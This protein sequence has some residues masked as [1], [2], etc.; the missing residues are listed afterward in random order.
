METYRFGNW[1]EKLLCGVA[2]LLVGST[3]GLAQTAE[4][5]APTSSLSSGQVDT[6]KPAIPT[7]QEIILDIPSAVHMSR[8]QRGEINGLRYVLFP[9]GTGTVMQAGELRTALYRLKCTKGV[10]CTITGEGGVS[11]NVP[12]RGAPE[13][14]LPIAP[15]GEALA[16]YLSEWILAGTGTP[17]ETKPPVEVAENKAP[18]PTAPVAEPADE[19]IAQTSDEPAEQSPSEPAAQDPEPAKSTTTS[20]DQTPPVEESA[21]PPCPVREENGGCAP[22]PVEERQVEQIRKVTYEPITPA[23]QPAPL[24]QKSGKKQEPAEQ[25]KELERPSFFKRIGLACSITGSVTSRYKNHNTGSERFGKP[26][27]SFGC[28]ARFSKKF[29][30]RLSVIGY[31]DKNEKSPSDADFTY[32]F[33][34]RATDKITLTYTNY[35]ARFDGAGGGIAYPFTSGALRASYKL[36][37]IPLPND[38]TIGCSTSLSLLRPHEN[39]LNL[40]CSYQ[41]TDRFRISGTAYA[42]TSGKQ[43]N[44]EPDFA[45]VA[46]YKINDDLNL[47]YSNYANNR[48][49]WNDSSS[50]GE[51]IYGGTLSLT[52]NFKF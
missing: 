3:S 42:Y 8:H 26:R 34:Y 33:A 38:K 43:E 7:A 19:S 28:G 37:R 46:S 17:I 51:G 10:S 27:V 39:S 15:N 30:V 44:W 40:S 25:P 23:S 1:K 48:F 47:V 50:P 36:P 49:F 16:R 18:A 2:V 32:A 45:Y 21:T 5:I 29:S 14:V 52:Y 13:P 20:S 31:G 12:A 6:T 4:Q 11:I 9:D 22:A 41:V 24:T 35:S